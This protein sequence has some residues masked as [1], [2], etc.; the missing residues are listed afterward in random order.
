MVHKFLLPT[1]CGAC[2]TVAGLAT[3]SHGQTDSLRWNEFKPRVA[4]DF[5]HIVE[6]YDGNPVERHPINRVTVTL[7]QSASYE[8]VWEVQ[9]GF[10]GV[11][12]WPFM[13]NAHDPSKRNM[14]GQGGLS[15]LQARRNFGETAFL[16]FGYIP[17]KYNPDAQNLGEYLHRSST[18]PGVVRTTDAMHL[19]NHALYEGL[20]AHARVSQR[21]GMI[22]HDFTLFSE[23]TTV[24]VGDLTPGYELSVNLPLVQF[25]AGAA[26]HRLIAYD[27]DLNRRRQIDNAY[28]K[29][30]SVGVDTLGNP[31]PWSGVLGLLPNNSPIRNRIQ[32]GDP[33]VRATHYYTQRGLKLMARAAFELGELVI[34]DA[35]RRPGDLRVFAEAALLGWDDQ[36]F[37][38]EDRL[39]RIPVMFGTHIPTAGLLDRLTI[40]SEYYASRFNNSK[41]FNENGTPVWTVNASYD[42]SSTTYNPAPLRRDDWKWSVNGSKTLNRL[43]TLHAQVANDHLRLPTFTGN[44][45]EAPLMREP[46]NWYYL[47]RLE[48]GL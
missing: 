45:S 15:R 44:P 21:G 3:L 23:L 37:Y 19:I 27:T 35:Y 18:Y 39:R 2:L 29:A 4:T 14:R 24:P 36:P 25:G 26:W 7:E 13:Q 11:L 22:V 32:N 40:Q 33:T 42:P 38:Y 20:G 46:G 17:Y 28:F 47:L 34:P 48:S 6:G 41:Q 12:W 30:D 8:D 9:A 5:G 1:L 10:R 43:L 31:V 16:E